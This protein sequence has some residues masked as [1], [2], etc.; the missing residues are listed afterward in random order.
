LPQITTLVTEKIQDPQIF[1][2]IFTSRFSRK[3]KGFITDDNYMDSID[4]NI[5]PRHTRRLSGLQIYSKSLQDED[6]QAL[7]KFDFFALDIA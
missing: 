7:S 6:Y 5:D 2:T 3:L 1:N 4:P